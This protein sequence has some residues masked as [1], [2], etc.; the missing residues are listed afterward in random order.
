MLLTLATVARV[1]LASRM[2]LSAEFEMA[3]D[4]ILNLER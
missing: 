3:I 2:A 4:T 1:E